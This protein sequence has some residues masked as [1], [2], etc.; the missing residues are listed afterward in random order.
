MKK[1]QD[2]II[3]TATD[4]EGRTVTLSEERWDHIKNR[5][6]EITK[7]S[8]VSTTVSKPLVII[9]NSERESLTYSAQGRSTLLMNVHAS[10]TSEKTL[11]VRTAHLSA[12]MPQGDVIWQQSKK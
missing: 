3:L 10:F 8:E 6:P 7:I 5:H 11:K 1:N 9:E 12:K 2:N 4:P